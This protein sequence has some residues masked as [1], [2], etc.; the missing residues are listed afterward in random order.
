MNLK[1]MT[2]AF[3]AIADPMPEVV[4]QTPVVKAPS[5]A[6]IVSQKLAELKAKVKAAGVPETVTDV[7]VPKVKAVKEVKVKAVKVPKV[8]AVKEVKVKAVKVPKVKAPKVVTD[9]DE[10]TFTV[11]GSSVRKGEMKMRFAND[12]V[13]RVKILEKDKHTDINLVELPNPMTKAEI[14]A[15]FTNHPELGING[16]ALDNKN[17]AMAARSKK[18]AVAEAPAVVEPTV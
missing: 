1:K 12:L 10:R 17:V 16:V 5:K 8:K 14:V 3:A 9:T 18:Q 4:A 15:Y 11:A 2:M 6:N 7:K 13:S